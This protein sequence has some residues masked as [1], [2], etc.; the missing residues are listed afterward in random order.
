MGL[1]NGIPGSS[2]DDNYYA[3][4][5]YLRAVK[6][7]TARDVRQARQQGTS[8]GYNQGFDDGQQSGYDM[9]WNDGIER[10][11]RELMK[12]DGYIKGYLADNER[13]QQN[14][15]EQMQQIA[16]LLA[17]VEALE[18]AIERMQLESNIDPDGTQVPNRS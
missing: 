4:A 14:A 8:E 1:V 3:S 13:L 7:G 2:S 12:A 11:N 5:D 18:D 9:G 16:Q 6:L 15:N 10:G 17:H